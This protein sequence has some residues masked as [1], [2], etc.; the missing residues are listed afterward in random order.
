MRIFGEIKVPCAY[1][2]ND[3]MTQDWFME[4]VANEITK[5][6]LKQNLIKFEEKYINGYYIM[7][8]FVEVDV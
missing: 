5:E 6:L 3:R 7:D 2:A 8:G 1:M 4:R